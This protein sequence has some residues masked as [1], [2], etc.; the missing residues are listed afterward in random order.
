M[1]ET[2]ASENPI[3]NFLAKAQT[4][5]LIFIKCQENFIP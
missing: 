4:F 5:Q 2:T 1:F 3:A